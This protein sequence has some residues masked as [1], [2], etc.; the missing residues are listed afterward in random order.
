MKEIYIIYFIL[1]KKKLIL[2]NTRSLNYKAFVLR[3]IKNNILKM[4]EYVCSIIEQSLDDS[5]SD[6]IFDF[7]ALC[8]LK[9]FE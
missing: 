8:G 6:S 2:Y 9:K 5:R 7:V 4:S 3:Y 1:Y